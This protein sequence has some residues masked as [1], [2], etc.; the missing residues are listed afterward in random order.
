MLILMKNIYYDCF[1]YKPGRFQK[2][3]GFFPTH[4]DKTRPNNVRHCECST[5]ECGSPLQLS[6]A[7]SFFKSAA[8][9][10]SGD[11]FVSL[12]MTGN[13]GGGSFGVSLLR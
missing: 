10:T 8:E 9:H 11:C 7:A 4:N 6:Y 1:R 12:A 3:A 13:G 5:A 2:H